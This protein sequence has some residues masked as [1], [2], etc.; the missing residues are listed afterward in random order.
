MLRCLMLNCAHRCFVRV[1]M[2]VF[3]LLYYL[4]IVLLAIY[5]L[6]FFFD[7]FACVAYKQK[8][9]LKGFLHLALS[10]DKKWK[11]LPDPAGVVR[12]RSKQIFFVRHGERFV[13]HVDFFFFFFCF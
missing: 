8:L 4:V 12:K 5:A 10:T 1:V 2:D 3:S 11:K 6:S 13:G 7:S 9:L